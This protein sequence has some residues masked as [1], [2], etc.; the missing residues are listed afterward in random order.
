MDPRGE[1]W[2][3]DKDDVALGRQAGRTGVAAIGTRTQRKGEKTMRS[4]MRMALDGVR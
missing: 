1:L 3:L 4:C 2:L